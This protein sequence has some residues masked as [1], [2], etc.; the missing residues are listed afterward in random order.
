MTTRSEVVIDRV[1]L[2][3]SDLDR[4]EDDYVATFGAASNNVVISILR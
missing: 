2:I 4:A 1:T 3:V